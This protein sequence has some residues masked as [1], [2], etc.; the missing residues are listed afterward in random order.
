M[1]QDSTSSWKAFSALL[2]V[3]EACS[4]QKVV[5]MLEEVV[6]GWWKVRWIW[7]MRQNCIAQIVQL[8]KHWLCNMGSGIVVA[9]NWAFSVDSFLDSESCRGSDGLQT[10]KQW[11][12]PF[13]GISLV[14]GSVLKLLLSPTTELVITNCCIKSSFHHRSQFDREMV[15]CCCVE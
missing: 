13:Y 6:V 4:L 14:W 5:E 7:C 11:L 12:R 15:H 10:T 2:L 8:L 1:L 9:K 3:V